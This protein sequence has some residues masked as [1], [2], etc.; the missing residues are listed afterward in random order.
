MFAYKSTFIPRNFVVIGA[1]GTGS[2]LVPMLAQFIKTLGWVINPQ[3]IIFDPDVV[4]V[5]NL[6][7]QNFIPRDVGKNKAQVLAERYSKHFEMNIYAVAGEVGPTQSNIKGM[8]AAGIPNVSSLADITDAVF[9]L[10]VDSVQARLNII[11]NIYS[12]QRRCLVLDAGNEDDFGQVTIHTSPPSGYSLQAIVNAMKELPLPGNLV[13]V[14]VQV[15]GIPM[16]MTDYLTLEPG[17]ASGG[18]AD[19][20]QTL[21]VNAQMAVNMLSIFQNF[22]YNKPIFYRRLNVSL[23]EGAQPQYITLPWILS[24]HDDARWSKE[25]DKTSPFFKERSI[26]RTLCQNTLPSHHMVEAVAASLAPAMID[27]REAAGLEIPSYFKTNTAYWSAAK[28]KEHVRNKLKEMAPEL[29]NDKFLSGLTENDIRF[30]IESRDATARIKAKFSEIKTRLDL[31]AEDA[32]AE[33]RLQEERARLEA[34]ISARVQR[35]AGQTPEARREERA[36]TIAEIVRANEEFI[37]NNF[38]PVGTAAP[39][40]NAAR[41]ERARV[42]RTPPVPTMADVTTT[43]VITRT[44]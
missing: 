35:T 20:D 28:K 25:L 11:S 39:L 9:F 30:I 38:A 10:C 29:E 32:R 40:P 2:R 42:R 31:A 1:G 4:E 12:V 7:R 41:P 27:L 34:A 16:D 36:E 44:I 21:A 8:A 17:A 37:N 15:T 3:I 13:P 22:V 24:V 14:D 33:V 23:L 18:C 19:L 6:V 26:L 43:N 5:K